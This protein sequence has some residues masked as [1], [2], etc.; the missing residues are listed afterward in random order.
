MEVSIHEGQGDLPDHGILIVRPL[1][2][3]FSKQQSSANEI[4]IDFKLPD[5]STINKILSSK[6]QDDKK[7]W[8]VAMV[9]SEN[10]NSP[11]GH[12]NQSEYATTFGSYNPKDN[13]YR[14][15]LHSSAKRI[16][17]ALVARDDIYIFE[18][19]SGQPKDVKE[20]EKKGKKEEK[21]RKENGNKNLLKMNNKKNLSWAISC[22][23]EEQDLRDEFCDFSNKS[24]TTPQR[25]VIN[26]A[27]KAADFL[28]IGKGTRAVLNHGTFL[29][30]IKADEELTETNI[31]LPGVPSDEYN[32]ITFSSDVS[33]FKLTL[34]PGNI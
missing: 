15:R 18:D 5:P 29:N 19:G 32:F 24:S 4:T 28:S 10:D 16:S 23:F 13:T 26:A 21:P 1:A 2:L 17:V 30:I 9:K 22:E 25:M 3:Q 34:F 11:A 20:E 14:V 7:V 8:L 31:W 12:F 6:M 27:I 33:W